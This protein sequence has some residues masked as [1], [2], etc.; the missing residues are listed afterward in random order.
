MHNEHAIQSLLKSAI[1]TPPGGQTGYVR[2]SLTVD[3]FLGFGAG[4]S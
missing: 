2:F 3:S 4:L 1:P